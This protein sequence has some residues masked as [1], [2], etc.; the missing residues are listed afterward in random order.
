MKNLII[1]SIIIAGFLS[2]HSNAG[3]DKNGYDI[4]GKLAAGGGKTIFLDKLSMAAA[5]P[6][7]TAI[8][9]TD[10]SFELK[11][12]ITEKGLYLLRITQ[13]KTWLLV[14]DKGVVDFGG[15]FN[16]IYTYSVKGSPESVWLTNFVANIG[17]KNGQLAKLNQD[18]TQARDKGATEQELQV[19]QN[20]YAQIT[21]QIQVDIHTF[22]DT[23]KSGL[24]A[25]FS[26]GL[27]DPSQNTAFMSQVVKKWQAKEPNNGY[28]NELA[29]KIAPFT[30]LAEGQE[31]PDFEM[32]NPKGETIK[33]SSLRGTV[34]LLD[35][36]ASWCRPCRAENP[37]VVAAYGKYKD[38]GFTVFSI[39]FDD[40][41][42]NWV[43]AIAQDGL[44]WPTHASELKKWNSEV[45]HMYN[46]NSIPMSFLIGKDGKIVAKNLRGIELDNKLHE[47]LGS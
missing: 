12:N 2:C 31:A 8:I 29:A 34:V 40:N 46:V 14:L 19:M 13:D 21:N 37:N 3:S 26:A 20:Q 30:K 42:Q 16:N 10:G 5:T 15:D 4:K 39:S 22:A 18:F 6:V 27:L 32:K 33:L 44:I 38:K 41:A 7:D 17:G 1:V 35:F 24:L 43:Q 45:G 28:V 36:W 25:A 47:L 23:V 9:A 11:G